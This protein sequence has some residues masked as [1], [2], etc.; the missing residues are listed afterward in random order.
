MEVKQLIELVMKQAEEKDFGMTPEDTDVIRK[1]ASI[2]SEV[3]EVYDAYRKKQF[4]GPRNFGE[5]LGDVMQRVLH[6][7]GVFN[8]DIE[9]EILDKMEINKSRTWEN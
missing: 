4:E 9:K 3:S 5:E 8:I 7:C 1:I 2:H 6:L